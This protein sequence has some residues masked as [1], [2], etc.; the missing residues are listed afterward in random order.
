MFFSTRFLFAGWPVHRPNLQTISLY[1]VRFSTDAV[2]SN[3]IFFFFFFFVF[4]V[5]FVVSLSLSLSLSLFSL[6]SL[7][8]FYI[9][10]ACV[11]S[12][13]QKIYIL[14][15]IRL[16]SRVGDKKF[17]TPT[18]SRNKA[19]F[20]GLSYKNPTYKIDCRYDKSDYRIVSVLSEPFEKLHIRREP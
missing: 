8:F 4:F 1:P 15:Q 16:C 7:V 5:C 6:V 3:K 17:F 14:T 9:S 20:F 19:K 10:F 13:N 12:F 18:I 2:H 11:L